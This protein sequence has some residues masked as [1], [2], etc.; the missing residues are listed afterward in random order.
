MW[1]I[2]QH[3][4]IGHQKNIIFVLLN[5]HV[6]ESVWFD[7]ENNWKCIKNAIAANMLWFTECRCCFWFYCHDCIVEIHFSIAQLLTF[8]NRLGWVASSLDCMKENKMCS[9]SHVED[10]SNVWEQ[11]NE[12][13]ADNDTH[14]HT[15]HDAKIS[16]FTFELILKMSTRL[17]TIPI[18]VCQWYC[19]RIPRATLYET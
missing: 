9:K 13:S 3:A 17:R 19:N 18:F 12:K 15:H 11:S 6:G 14:T 1:F 7:S 5:V 16:K 10:T 2:S 8:D 4:P